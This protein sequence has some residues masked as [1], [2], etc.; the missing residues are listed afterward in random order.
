MATITQGTVL[1]GSDTGS[2]TPMAQ[3]NGHT[4]DVSPSIIRGFTDMKI[5]GGSDT[6]TKT[7]NKQKYVKREAGSVSEI[8]MAINLHAYLGIDDV[9][10]EAMGFVE[11]ANAGAKDYFY[12]GSAK[13]FPAKMMLTSAEVI[14]IVHFPGQGRRWI[15]CKVNVTFKQASK[16]GK[17]SKKKKKKKNGKGKSGGSSSGSSKIRR[18]GGGVSV[19][20]QLARSRTG[21]VSHARSWNSMTKKVAELN[22]NASRTSAATKNKFGGRFGT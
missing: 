18:S 22:K 9:Y 6:K 13:L 20:E 4:F 10:A 12:L 17:A 8:S 5:K 14:E 7:K 21:T 1:S 3:W 16:S 19:A 11:E 2:R 15:S